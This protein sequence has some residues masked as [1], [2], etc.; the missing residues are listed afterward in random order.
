MGLAILPAYDSFDNVAANGVV[1]T[2]AVNSELLAY[3]LSVQQGNN[4]V[5][6]PD[7]GTISQNTL[8]IFASPD[9]P[10]RLTVTRFAQ[11]TA[12]G[13]VLTQSVISDDLALEIVNLSLLIETSYCRV[14][15]GYYNGSCLDVAFD[16]DKKRSLDI[17]FKLLEN[18]QFVIK[19]AREFHGA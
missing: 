2:R 19:Q 15:R 11:P 17:E 12:E 14:K 9:R 5:T 10:A 18:G 4:L 16:P 3:T 1:I 6:N 8:A 13:P 7:P